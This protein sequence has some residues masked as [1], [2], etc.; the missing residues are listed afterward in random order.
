MTDFLSLE[1]IEEARSRLPP[2]VR[3]TPVVPL[4]RGPGEV[5]GER[6]YLKLENLQ[7]TGSYKAR[8]AFHFLGSLTPEERARGV[9]LASS[10]NFGQAF[11]Y[12]GKRLDVPVAVVTPQRTSRFKV[13]AIRGYGADLVFCEDSFLARRP[14]VDEVARDRGM[15]P[16]DTMEDRRVAVGHASIGLEILEDLPDVEA[17]IVPVG[18]GGLVAGV[19]S[20]IKL[21]APHVRVVGAQPAAGAAMY[22]SLEAGEP[23]TIGD[24]KTMAD[25]LWVMRIYAF[26]FAH[27]RERVDEVVLV[28]EDEIAEAFRVLLHRGKVLGEPAGAVPVA[29]YLSGK[30]NGRSKTVAVVSG[31]NVNPE[32]AARLAAA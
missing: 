18:S 32:L 31:G 17:V 12:A 27:V 14:K 9:V 6:L 19:A 29:A 16:L 25:A 1:E 3:H 23:L 2:E 20:A 5:G 22:R 30:V 28:S 7:V 4:A 8:A 15:V 26:P 24:Y 11:A 21:R 10:G 13:E